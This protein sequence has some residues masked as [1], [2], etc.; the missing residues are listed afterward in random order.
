MKV[1]Y[2]RSREQ[3]TKILA[4]F[5]HKPVAKVSLELFLSIGAV[6][7]FAVFAIQPTLVTMSDLIKELEDKRELDQKLQQKVAALSTAQT[8]YQ[9]IEPQLQYLEEAI[10][11]SPRLIEALL[12]IEKTASE[13]GVV[14]DSLRVGE[15]PEEVEADLTKANTRRVAIPISMSISG[16]YPTLRSYLI[17]LINLRRTFVIDTISFSRSSGRGSESLRATVTLSMPFYQEQAA[18]TRRGSARTAAP[19]ALEAELE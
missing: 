5:Y 2:T 1:D 4:D 3:I 15:V 10:P 16:S 6:L 8:N 7:F 17:D 19:D 11:S 12:L 18:T 13:K 14:I 9:Q